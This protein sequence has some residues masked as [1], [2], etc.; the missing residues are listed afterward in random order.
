MQIV[1]LK[2]E[3]GMLD[4]AVKELK[5]FGECT[6]NR[7]RERVKKILNKRQEWSIILLF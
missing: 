4:D 7:D 3:C 6:G 1:G 5:F 2:A